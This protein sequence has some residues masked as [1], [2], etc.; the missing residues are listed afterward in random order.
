MRAVLSREGARRNDGGKI[1]ALLARVGALMDP[2]ADAQ[3]NVPRDAGDVHF[4]VLVDLLVGRRWA[5]VTDVGR[6][7]SVTYFVA[8]KESR[9]SMQLVI[10]LPAGWSADISRCAAAVLFLRAVRASDCCPSR[11]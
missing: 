11:P 10:P 4:T 8:V 7:D 3:G 9:M 1:D 2:E 5:E 6:K